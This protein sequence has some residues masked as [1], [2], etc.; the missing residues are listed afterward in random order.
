MEQKVILVVDDEFETLE[1]VI[2]CLSEAFPA[3]QLMNASNGEKALELMERVVPQLVL[4]DWEM[5]E[6]NG[7]R[8]TQ[9]MK[10]MP[11]LRDTA[12]IIM[13][14]KKTSSTDLEKALEVGSIDYLS[15]PLDEIELK[16]RVRSV[17]QLVE[18][19]LLSKQQHLQIQALLQ[20]EKQRLEEELQEKKQKLSASTLLDVEKQRLFQHIEKTFS[21]ISPLSAEMPALNNLLLELRSNIKKLAD[22]NASWDDFRLHFEE[23]HP[24]F[25]K[26]LSSITD[27][28]TIQDT[29]LA[30]YLKLGMST[31]EIANLS[32]ISPESA[33]KSVYRLRKK[34]H[35]TIKDDDFRKF[36]IELE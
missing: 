26:Q 33:R 2:T 31:K 3:Y 34:F 17:L 6:L 1:Q 29:K 36:M 7:Y 18:T 25:F 27:H 28:L 21:K 19:N 30:V 32:N 15:K 24:N 16:A 20:S 14:G 5:P 12:I 13:S 8:L 11:K 10:S 35:V 9:L 4:T 23:V 22:L